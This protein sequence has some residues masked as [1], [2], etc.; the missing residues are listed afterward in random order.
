MQDFLRKMY[1][2]LRKQPVAQTEI[3]I[4]PSKGLRSVREEFHKSTDRPPFSKKTQPFGWALSFRSPL[5]PG[6]FRSLVSPIIHL[7]G[8]ILSDFS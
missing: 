2:R 7:K 3:R 1:E 8:F 6:S 4:S 5:L